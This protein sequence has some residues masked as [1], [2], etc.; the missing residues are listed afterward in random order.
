MALA[1]GRFMARTIP[2]IFLDCLDRV[3][4]IGVRQKIMHVHILIRPFRAGN[5]KFPRSRRNL[6][7]FAVCLAEVEAEYFPD[8]VQ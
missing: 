5:G 1:F 7:Q 2:Q 3:H 6:H 8:R 4:S